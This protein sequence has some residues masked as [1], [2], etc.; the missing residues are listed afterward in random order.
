MKKLLFGVLGFV[1]FAFYGAIPSLAITAEPASG[2]YAPNSV[3]TVVVR[4][5]DDIDGSNATAVQIRLSVSGPGSSIVAG[6]WD[7]RN[8]SNYLSIGTCTSNN[9]SETSDSICVDM[10]KTTGAV[11]GGEILGSFKIQLGTSG[12]T[13]V[14]EADGNGYLIGSSISNNDPGRNLAQFT[15]QND[16]TPTPTPLPV[17]AIGDSSILMIAGLSIIFAGVGFFIWRERSTKIAN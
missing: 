3:V 2:I 12:V 9:D 7:D 13:T 10:A 5:Y 8:A 1:V 14:Q 17:T 15:V 16:V 4:A 6:S 11:Q